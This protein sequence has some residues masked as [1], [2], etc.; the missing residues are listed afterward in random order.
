MLGLCRALSGQDY[1]RSTLGVPGWDRG[2]L[3]GGKGVFGPAR[4]PCRRSQ[5]G[6]YGLPPWQG[7]ESTRKGSESALGHL[8][9]GV[10]MEKGKPRAPAVL[11]AL[12]ASVRGYRPGTATSSNYIYIQKRTFKKIRTGMSW[13]AEPREATGVIVL[14]KAQPSVCLEAEESVSGQASG[15][16]SPGRASERCCQIPVQDLGGSAK[17]PCRMGHAQPK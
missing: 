7:A 2:Q 6:S 13:P 11:L 3:C 10:C 17:L 14:P 15:F 1:Q 4:A 8:G 9:S 12:P 16:C 5:A